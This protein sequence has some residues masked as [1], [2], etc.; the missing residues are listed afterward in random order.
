MMRLSNKS[1]SAIIGKSEAN[2]L[3]Y[4]ILTFRNCILFKYISDFFLRYTCTQAYNMCL[5]IILKLTSQFWRQLICIGIIRIIRNCTVCYLCAS[6]CCKNNLTAQLFNISLCKKR[7]AHRGWHVLRGHANLLVQIFVRSFVK[8]ITFGF[9][10]LDFFYRLFALGI[11]YFQTIFGI[12][13]ISHFI[14]RDAFITILI[15]Q[16]SLWKKDAC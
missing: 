2:L 3:Q 16:V 13:I 14:K 4:K 1:V 15:H 6:V 11:V 7:N 9:V 5:F 12:N 10:F 8:L